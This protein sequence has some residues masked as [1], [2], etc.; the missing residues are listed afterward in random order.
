MLFF[1]PFSFAPLSSPLFF[2]SVL[3][4]FPFYL[5]F[6]SFS[7]F[8]ELFLSVKMEAPRAFRI[9]ERGSASGRTCSGWLGEGPARALHSSGGFPTLRAAPAASPPRGVGPR[10]PA[11]RASR[12]RTQRS[13]RGCPR[14]P[15]P[16]AFRLLGPAAPLAGSSWGRG[17]S[18][19]A[20]RTAPPP[21]FLRSRSRRRAAGGAE[22]V[23]GR[24][25][26]RIPQRSVAGCPLPGSGSADGRRPLAAAARVHPLWQGLPGRR[27]GASGWV[28]RPRRNAR[29]AAACL[30]RAGYSSPGRGR[31]WQQREGFGA[32]VGQRLR[33]AGAASPRFRPWDAPRV[34]DSRGGEG[35]PTPNRVGRRG[36][37]DPGCWGGWGGGS[38]PGA[39]RLAASG[40]EESPGARRVFAP[41]WGASGRSTKTSPA[42]TV[43]LPAGPAGSLFASRK[44]NVVY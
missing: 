4:L 2:P 20:P 14:A 34:G 12:A 23:A 6:H 27:Q 32:D 16:L 37:W 24:Q 22:R 9:L 35:A 42:P 41:G 43:S 13:R 8:L 25:L 10:S 29:A 44:C 17:L 31:V 1:P 33:R 40:E 21:Q 36:R 28:S 38:R 5:S 26:L 7:T 11:S 15:R 18:R 39:A 3:G 30:G 19:P